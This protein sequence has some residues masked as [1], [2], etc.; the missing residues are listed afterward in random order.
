MGG[1]EDVRRFTDRALARLGSG[2]EAL[3]K[4]AYKAALATLP[5]DLRERLEAEGLSGT[6]LIS[7]SSTRPSPGAGRSSAATRSSPSSRRRSSS[8]RS[9]RPRIATVG[10]KRDPGVLGRVGCWIIVGVT[11]RTTVALLRLRH[12]LTSRKGRATSTLLVE[13]AAAIG[14]AGASS[15]KLVEGLDALALLSPAAA[16]DPPAHVAAKAVAQSLELLAGKT[17]ELDA[18]AKRRAEALLAD[19]R[20]V[21]EAGEAT[22][23]YT[24]KALLPAD[25]IGIF[26]LLP[27]VG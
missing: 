23:K 16:A 22:G 8:G 3:G 26:V 15:P 6:P 9:P 27:K 11:E 14:W 5:E 18:F 10:E 4:G 12:Q 19:H 24:V 21:R 13:E 20:R 17:G 1:D 2:L 25:V 7:T